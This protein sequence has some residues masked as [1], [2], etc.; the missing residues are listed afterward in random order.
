MN[1]FKHYVDVLFLTY[2]DMKL[3]D[4]DNIWL[5]D[6]IVICFFTIAEFAIK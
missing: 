6:R 4:S 5:N 1:S 3:F 2:H